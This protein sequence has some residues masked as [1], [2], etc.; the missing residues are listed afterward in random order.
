M[1]TAALPKTPIGQCDRPQTGVC[2]VPGWNQNRSLGADAW[3]ERK[4]ATTHAPIRLRP[5]GAQG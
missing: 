3:P 5:D 1:A 2:R 4:L